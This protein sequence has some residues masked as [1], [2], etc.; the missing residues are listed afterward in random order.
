M[1]PAN[2]EKPGAI[3]L[4]AFWSRQSAQGGEAGGDISPSAA[5]DYIMMKEFQY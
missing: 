3:S 1:P 4:D 5:S 2:K